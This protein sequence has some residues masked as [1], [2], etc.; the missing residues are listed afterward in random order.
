MPL[1]I[2]RTLYLLE[3]YSS[4]AKNRYSIYCARVRCTG[5]VVICTTCGLHFHGIGDCLLN[6]MRHIRSG[7]RK[8]ADKLLMKAIHKYRGP[9]CQMRELLD[10]DKQFIEENIML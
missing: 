7:H 9:L 6:L 8:H 10:M 2:S 4:V 5:K 1:I 3:E